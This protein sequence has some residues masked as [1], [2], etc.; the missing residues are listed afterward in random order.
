MRQQCFST[1]CPSLQASDFAV[2]ESPT[3]F[4]GICLSGGSLAHE[5]CV[6]KYMMPQQCYIWTPSEDVFL[7]GSVGDMPARSWPS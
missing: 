6:I 2:G 1:T 7:P 5:A 4:G 3:V